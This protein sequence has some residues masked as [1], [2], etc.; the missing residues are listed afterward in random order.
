MVTQASQ[1]VPCASVDS[2][3]S[4]CWDLPLD[5]SLDE[6]CDRCEFAIQSF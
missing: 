1:D 5:Y 6:G 2:P 3:C 4:R